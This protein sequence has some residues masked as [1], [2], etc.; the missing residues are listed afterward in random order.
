MPDRVVGD[1]DVVR[2]DWHDGTVC[3]L[4]RFFCGAGRRALCQILEKVANGTAQVAGN[5]NH[6]VRYEADKE[7]VSRLMVNDTIKDVGNSREKVEHELE[8]K[9]QRSS[10]WRT[11]RHATSS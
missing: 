8:K 4:C 5:Q 7:A 2:D 6:E 1:D 9:H 3:H 10:K 11:I